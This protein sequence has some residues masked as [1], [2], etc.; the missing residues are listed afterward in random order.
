MGRGTVGREEKR[1]KRGE[2]KRSGKRNS[3]KRREGNG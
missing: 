3:R 1:S 2:E